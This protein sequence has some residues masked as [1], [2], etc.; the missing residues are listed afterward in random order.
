MAMSMSTPQFVKQPAE[1]GFRAF[2]YAPTAPSRTVRQISIAQL[3]KRRDAIVWR[4]LGFEHDIA[5]HNLER[6]W[7][8]LDKMMEISVNSAI[9]IVEEAY[10]ARFRKL[11]PYEQQHEYPGTRQDVYRIAY[12]DHDKSHED[13][14]SGTLVEHALEVLQEQAYAL[15]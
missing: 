5:A 7:N 1:P 12:S 9:D 2:H 14:S 6:Y 15:L 4:L 10:Y 13:F 8:V 11:R 3:I